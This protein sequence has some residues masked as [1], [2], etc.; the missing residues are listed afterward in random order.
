MISVPLTD[1]GLW[2]TAAERAVMLAGLSLALGGLAGRGLGRQ[3]LARQAAAAGTG[4]P[5]P[6][7]GGPAGGRPPPPAALP[8]PWALRGSLLGAAACAALALTAWL[9]PGLAARLARPPVA[10]LRGHATL[11][12]ALA[13][14]ACF[15]AAA[16][17]ARRRLTGL[18][19]TALLGVVAAEGIRAHPEGMIP[20]A[21]AMLSYCHLTPGVVWAGLLA[22]TV[23]AALAWR[24]D[25]AAMQGLVRL[26][27]TAAAWLF[28]CVVVTGLITVLLVT[29]LSKILVTG[30]GLILV[31]KSALVAVAAGLAVAGR[32]WLRRAA[33]PGAGPARATR[34]ELAVLG[35]VL[36]VT[37][38]LTVVT[39]PAAP[40]GRLA[41]RPP[42]TPVTPVTRPVSAEDLLTPA[43]QMFRANAADQGGVSSAYRW[44]DGRRA[45]WP[46]G[47]SAR[48]TRRTTGS[49]RRRTA[50]APAPGAPR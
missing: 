4:T 35:A 19:V 1:P 8:G 23:R 16:L 34:A 39:P 32:R 50:P 40:I 27:A 38:L 14:L 12:A 41:S 47:A 5:L 24:A 25:P 45:R 18:A 7:D 11:W 43:A 37:A 26:Y 48:R 9:G 29:P 21:G 17:A 6:A 49:G 42:A 22:Y 31:V 36:A 20:A 15:A 33:A 2:L 10:G 3:Y 44:R 28:G 46:G 13:E 30:Y